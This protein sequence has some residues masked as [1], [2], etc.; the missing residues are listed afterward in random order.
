[1]TVQQVDRLREFKDAKDQLDAVV[2]KL[3]EHG[4]FFRK[5]SEGLLVDPVCLRLANSG[6]SAPID[7]SHEYTV[8]YSR[9][10]AAEIVKDLLAS[11]GQLLATFRQAYAALPPDEQALVGGQ[12]SAL[13]SRSPQRTFRLPRV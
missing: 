8:D 13:E 4:S 9:W 6:V 7:L 2:S 10:P 12:G 5:V 1:M 3:R 11:Y